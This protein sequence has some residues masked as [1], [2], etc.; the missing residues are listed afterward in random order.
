MNRVQF[1]IVVALSSLVVVFLFL[2]AVF[3][4]LAQ[5]AQLRIVAAQQVIQEGQAC[6]GRRRQLAIRVY[7]VIQQ[8]NDQALKDILLRQGITVKAAPA[9]SSGASAPA[10]SYETPAAPPSSYTPPPANSPMAPLP[11]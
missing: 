2:Q 6:E 5:H 3:A 9:S 11:H 7:Q 1:A 4:K 8:T 10:S